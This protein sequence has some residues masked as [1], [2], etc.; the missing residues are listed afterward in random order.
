MTSFF[1]KPKTIL[2]ALAVPILF[3]LLAS[4]QI[5]TVSAAL[6][7]ADL[8]EASIERPENTWL[9]AAELL[10]FSNPDVFVARAK[11]L[12][13][14]A[15]LPEFKSQR[16][17]IL[18]ETLSNLALAVEQRP[19]WPYYHLSELNILVLLGA[20]SSEVQSKVDEVL[21]LAPNERGLD[22]HFL[23]LA[24]HSWDKLSLEQR[25]WMLKRLVIVP[26]NTLRYV[27]SVAKNLNRQSVICT[28]LPYKKIKRL[29]KAR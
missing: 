29:C 16:S 25:Q 5:F 8:Q 26:G 24:F 17:E 9:D 14:K 20:E 21:L 11:F 23:E 13:Q 3:L 10:S 4:A 18:N 7:F 6:Y 27:F 1:K 12:R 22:K 19:L 28:N 2:I 15:L